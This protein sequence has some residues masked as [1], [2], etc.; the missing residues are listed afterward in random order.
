MNPEIPEWDLASVK[1]HYPDLNLSDEQAGRIY[2]FEQGTRQ[3]FTDALQF[4]VWE[5]KDYEW[6]AYRAILSPEQLAIY[7]RGR[8]E[9]IERHEA[10]LQ[11]SDAA[12]WKE[13]IAIW[14]EMIG[15]YKETFL[16]AVRREAMQ[17]PILPFMEQEKIVYLRGAYQQFLHKTHQD[18]LVRHY[19][20]SRT[21]QPNLLR[22]SLLREELLRLWPDHRSFFDWADAATQNM[23]VYV[24][25][26][27]K[28]AGSKSAAF[29]QQKAVEVKERWAAARTRHT[30]EPVIRGWHIAISEERWTE[31]E[32]GVM[33]VL[34]MAP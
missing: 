7:E 29:F 10:A 16:P 3:P 2:L 8:R 30:G 27:Y 19:R 23:A 28:G 15:W 25:E 6:D 5:E 22:L 18:T 11:K 21:F 33:A 12:E 34:I 24:L 14:E 32:L 1:R 13:E 4:S 20:Q 9:A 17:A 26:R 31:A